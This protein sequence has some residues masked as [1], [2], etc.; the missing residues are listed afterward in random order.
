VPFGDLEASQYDGRGGLDFHDPIAAAFD[1]R[2]GGVAFVADDRHVPFVDDELRA[3]RD[4]VGGQVNRRLRVFDAA[5]AVAGV[6]FDASITL[7]RLQPPL[8]PVE[9]TVMAAPADEQSESA[10]ST[11]A[12]MDADQKPS[13]R[14]MIDPPQQP[15]VRGILA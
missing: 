1:H 3:Q 5:A 15:I 7:R 12:A 4:R 14:V 8:S 9:S 13:T 2:P 11:E 10:T 6:C